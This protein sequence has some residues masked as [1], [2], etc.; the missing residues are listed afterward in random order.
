MH[1]KSNAYFIW[2]GRNDCVSYCWHGTDTISAT[3]NHKTARRRC[4][5]SFL[6]ISVCM[7][8]LLMS[9]M[10]SQNI[11]CDL[12]GRHM[13]RDII[14]KNT[15][16]NAYIYISGS[17]INAIFLHFS[18][19][20][21]MVFGSSAL[22]NECVNVEQKKPNGRRKSKRRKGTTATMVTVI[23]NWRI[24]SVKEATPHNAV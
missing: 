1:D 14:C 19:M 16:I 7:H 9:L 21:M 6:F 23:K 22:K 5:R 13:K 15:D 18:A 24:F 12:S 17:T 4:I 10:A 20:V 8:I 11:E 3:E 2:Y